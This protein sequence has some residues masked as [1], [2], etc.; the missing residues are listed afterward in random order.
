[1]RTKVISVA[2]QLLS[3]E[4][5]TARSTTASTVRDL[6][7]DNPSYEVANILASRY[8][9]VPRQVQCQLGIRISREL[10][11]PQQYV[12]AFI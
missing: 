2:D 5:H 10:Q 3:T 6:I 12:D 8:A 9:H 11:D 1:M 4:H 7:S